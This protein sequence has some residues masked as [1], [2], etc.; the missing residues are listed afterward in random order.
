MTP[1]QRAGELN[2][3]WYPGHM[4]KAARRIREYLRAVDI[5]V[6]VVD[7]R[8]ARSGRTPFLAELAARRTRVVALDRADLAD[9]ATTKR[10]LRHLSNDGS[11]ALAID[12]RVRGSVARIAA[13]MARA[14]AERRGAGVSRAMIV[15]VPNSGKSTIVNSLV[16]RAA[17]KTED[18]A[19]VTRQTQW[20]RVARGVELLDTP[21]VLAPK[22]PDSA[23]HWKLAICGALPRD[24]YDPQE[25]ASAFHSWIVARHPRSAVP[26]LER[27]A[28]RR[29]FIRRRGEVDYH[30]AAQSYIRAFNDGAFG[31]IS[32]ED[33]D[34]AEAA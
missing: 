16:G 29:G 15:G 1:P 28:E 14:S 21:G 23:T 7:A 9:P 22:I 34:D 24:R 2:L 12:A 3:S 30:N 5:V 19:G 13:A 6:E 4:A 20:F 25:V 10:W 31:R 33:V 26:D 8:I 11:T 27:F 18:R 17:A 32:L